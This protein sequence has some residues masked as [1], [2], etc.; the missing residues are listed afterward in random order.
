MCGLLNQWSSQCCTYIRILMSQIFHPF[1]ISLKGHPVQLLH[2]NLV[3][4]E[5]TGQCGQADLPD[6]VEN[7]V[8][9][10]DVASDLSK[11][12][13]I[14]CQNPVCNCCFLC[15]IEHP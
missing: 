1:S 8:V 10:Y 14:V 6:V 9:P 2:L 4:L 11:C 12:D 7:G 15:L 13:G 3:T 5:N